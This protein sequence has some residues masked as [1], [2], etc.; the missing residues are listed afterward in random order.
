MLGAFYDN[1]VPAV[2]L[3]SNVD[4]LARSFRITI[5]GQCWELVRDNP[6]LP[7]RR[8]VTNHFQSEKF[9]DDELNRENM[10]NGTSVYRYQR[11]VQLLSQHFPLN[12]FKAA[13][14]LRNYEGLD[15]NNIGLG[16]E[17]AVNQIADKF[18]SFS[19]G[20]G[21]D[22]R[23]SSGEYCLENQ[24]CPVPIFTSDIR[25]GHGKTIG[26]KKSISCTKHEC[27]SN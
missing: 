26:S 19:H 7:S 2:A 15:D 24:K 25:A 27:E 16:N 11:A 4:S 1:V 9:Q 23:C 12:E 21:N 13:E 22:C 10:E 5:W 3:H 14:I 17:K 20:T 18:R 8:V 6:R